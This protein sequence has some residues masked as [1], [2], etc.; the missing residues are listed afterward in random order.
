[1]ASL[2]QQ[3]KESYKIADETFANR[4]T[5]SKNYLLGKKVSEYSRKCVA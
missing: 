4:Q 2:A 1:M 3:T 5:M